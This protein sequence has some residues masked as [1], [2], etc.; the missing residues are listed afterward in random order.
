MRVE[1]EQRWFYSFP[2]GSYWHDL[3]GKSITT[4]IACL[5]HTLLTKLQFHSSHI[6][7]STDALTAYH[8]SALIAAQLQQNDHLHHILN[9]CLTFEWKKKCNVE[10]ENKRRKMLKERQQW[11]ELDSTKTGKKVSSID[12][13]FYFNISEERINYW[14]HVMSGV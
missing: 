3:R 4:K 6:S 14:L 9:N 10:K 13:H 2:E 12:Y 7:V 11:M 5:L 1:L 8:S